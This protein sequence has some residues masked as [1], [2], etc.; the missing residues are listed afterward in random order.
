MRI[1][2]EKAEPFFAF[3]RERYEVMLRRNRGEPAPW[4]RDPVLRA[5]RFC[6]VFRED[7]RTTVWFRENIRQPLRDRPV[8][9]LRATVLFRWFNLI[10][11]GE[12]MLGCGLLSGAFRP[13]EFRQKLLARRPKGPWVTGAY[14]V[15]TPAGMNKV[16]GALLCAERV[17]AD[18]EQLAANMGP[19][20]ERAHELLLGYPYV[21]NFFGYQLV[22][23]LRYTCLLER[24]TDKY[25]WA[26]PGPGSA[27]G[28]GAICG[29][30]FD[31][32]SDADRAV[33]VG[34]M[35]ELLRHSQDKR[36]WPEGW[37][38][39]ELSTVQHWACEWAKYIKAQR[40]DRLKRRFE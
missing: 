14:M 30:E 27:Q 3:A 18:A 36:M 32:N 5:W 29:R 23:D 7:D 15:K 4:T 28:L 31:Y 6:N 8:D 21:G 26:S 11:T 39:W 38:P 1:A 22:C 16:D 24:A 17:C 37:V 12:T 2:R 25:S 20:L 40:G 19:S 13:G 35:R 34:A 33:M 9:V 10:E